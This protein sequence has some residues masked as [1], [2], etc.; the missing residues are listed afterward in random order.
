MPR[1]TIPQ[2]FHLILK[3]AGAVRDQPGFLFVN[4]YTF[5]MTEVFLLWHVHVD[6]DLPGGED[7]KLLGV[8]SNF[9]NALA[10]QNDSMKLPGF[11]DF[12]ESFEIVSYTLDKREWTGGFTTIN[13]STEE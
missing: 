7:S 11:K 6:P 5:V 4:F 8:Y 10:A 12:P 9:E 13:S 1:Q 3:N 2:L